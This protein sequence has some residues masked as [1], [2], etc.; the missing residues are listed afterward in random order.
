MWR[1]RCCRQAFL[2][3]YSIRC[4]TFHVPNHRDRYEFSLMMGGH[5]FY[6][7]SSPSSVLWLCVKIPP[8]ART[9]DLRQ[10][11]CGII[12]GLWQLDE[13]TLLMLG[14]KVI[15]ATWRNSYLNW[16]YAK[17]TRRAPLSDAQVGGYQHECRRSELC[18][19]DRSSEQHASRSHYHW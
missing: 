14:T 19:K 1:T 6:V 8:H 13:K 15:F 11:F 5:D 3:A 17:K 7:R 4:A 10:W 18:L 16:L 9:R 12:F 2:G